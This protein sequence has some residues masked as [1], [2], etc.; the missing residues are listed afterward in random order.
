MTVGRAKSSSCLWS[1]VTDPLYCAILKM[2]HQD[3]KA[4]K[5]LTFKIALED[6]HATLL[7]FDCTPDTKCSSISSGALADH[8][9]LS[10]NSELH[11]SHSFSLPVAGN[12]HDHMNSSSSSSSGVSHPSKT[13]LPRKCALCDEIA[14]RQFS[15]PCLC[16]GLTLHVSL[17]Q[18]FT[19]QM[20]RRG[21]K[22]TAAFNSTP[23]VRFEGKEFQRPLE[24]A[25]SDI[26]D[27]TDPLLSDNSMNNAVQSQA[28][29]ITSTSSESLPQ[30]PSIST[31]SRLQCDPKEPEEEFEEV[32]GG[33]RPPCIFP[34][35]WDLKSMAEVR[36]PTVPSGYR[37]SA[38]NPLMAA[39]SILKAML[40]RDVQQQSPSQVL[41]RTVFFD[42]S[43]TSEETALPEDFLDDLKRLDPSERKA[44]CHAVRFAMDRSKCKPRPFKREEP[45]QN[46]ERTQENSENI[47]PSL[48]TE[49]P[50]KS[51]H[52]RLKKKHVQ[53]PPAAQKRKPDVEPTP[54]VAQKKF[55]LK[56][57]AKRKSSVETKPIITKSR[58]LMQLSANQKRKIGSAPRTVTKPPSSK[59]TQQ[60]ALEE[61]KVEADNVAEEWKRATVKT[62][63][64]SPIV[65]PQKENSAALVFARHP[66]RWYYP[67][68][69]DCSVYHWDRTTEPVMIHYA[70]GA[71]PPKAQIPTN[72]LP[73]ERLPTGSRIQLMDGED[74]AIDAI[75]ESYNL[76]TTPGGMVS[77]EFNISVEGS[78]RL[79][80]PFKNVAL[81]PLDVVELKKTMRDG[82]YPLQGRRN[83]T[84]VTSTLIL[85]NRA[86][87]SAAVDSKEPKEKVTPRALVKKPKPDTS[88]EKQHSIKEEKLPTAKQYVCLTTSCRSIF[89]TRQDF[90]EHVLHT[91]K[92]KKLRHWSAMTLDLPRL[93]SFPST[94]TYAMIPSNP[95]PQRRTGDSETDA[96][97]LADPV[98]I[99]SIGYG[100][101]HDLVVL[102]TSVKSHCP[103]KGSKKSE[104]KRSEV[105]KGLH[106]ALTKGVRNIPYQAPRRSQPQ[107]SESDSTDAENY[108]V[109]PVPFKEAELQMAIECGG[110]KF[111]GRIDEIPPKTDV[112]DCILVSDHPTVTSSYVYAVARGFRIIRHDS[113]LECYSKDINLRDALSHGT[114]L[115]A[116]TLLSPGWDII[117]QRWVEPRNSKVSPLRGSRVVSLFQYTSHENFKL[118]WIALL[119]YVGATTA[120]I[121]SRHQKE[122]LY[123]DPSECAN[124]ILMTDG[125][126]S[127]KTETL[128]NLSQCPLVTTEWLIQ[129]VITGQSP[130][131]S[132]FRPSA[133]MTDESN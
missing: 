117:K 52:N 17:E 2:L 1:R 67:A 34:K 49:T 84:D 110:G 23:K 85:G 24:P 74:E 72:I 16:N 101:C 21:R 27:I 89:E 63:A 6:N 31:E 45:P 28:S 26:I 58:R 107:D 3:A 42:E 82:F 37:A 125:P 113:I 83:F 65:S 132:R 55:Q 129:A 51:A 103:K 80:V 81:A 14:D 18:R 68:V 78:P 98:H 100:L 36:Y 40:K 4:K 41:A 76:I 71:A 44:M 115:S 88:C 29:D 39:L 61:R 112:D 19:P 87:R 62:E 22:R 106:F 99:P 109:T 11:T 116:I 93:Y 30:K 77:A 57:I 75:F 64:L 15:M 131:Y 133:A 105:F 13:D 43:V 90:D 130:P 94:S 50:T 114:H 86:R 5:I 10:E 121:P 97:S 20:S 73:L 46:L 126:A 127:Q 92:N 102:D 47:E 8:S 79:G 32:F 96:S 95:P 123:I 7:S 120:N 124:Y 91:I 25:C 12:L 60:T 48:D 128:A 33:A 59:V 69:M 53:Q 118:F 66:D 104:S 35:G 108:Y 119:R 122:S 111:Y 9:S 70:D 54:V 56:P 38:Y